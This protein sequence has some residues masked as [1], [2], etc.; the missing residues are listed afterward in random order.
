[1]NKYSNLFK[2]YGAWSLLFSWVPI[3]GDPLTFISGVFKTNFT[4]FL[5][6]VSIG[7]VTRY[8]AVIYSIN[9]FF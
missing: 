7:K 8:I 3:I 4:K 5:I 6:L 9:I 2:K 1:L